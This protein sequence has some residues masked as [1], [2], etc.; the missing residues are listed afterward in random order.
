MILSAD[1]S[2]CLSRGSQKRQRT[3]AVQNADASLPAS[4]N[5]ER[6]GLRLSSAALAGKR[7][8]APE[9]PHQEHPGSLSPECC[10][11]PSWFNQ[12]WT[13]ASALFRLS[14]PPNGRS[15][16]PPPAPR[17]CQS[18]PGL[19]RAG[20]WHVASGMQ[21]RCYEG[22]SMGLRWDYEGASKGIKGFYPLLLQFLPAHPPRRSPFRRS[23]FLL[24]PL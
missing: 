3:A 23:A 24:A 1:D 22:A 18:P 13:F 6:L 10:A 15:P 16:P 5:A 19:R 11:A 9:T 4:E 2:V 8:R 20:R 7:M 17:R 21:A 12:P 14:R